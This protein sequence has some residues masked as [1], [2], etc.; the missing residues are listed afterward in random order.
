MF[1]PISLNSEDNRSLW[2]IGWVCFFWST[3]SLM[4]F[5]LLPTFLTE[6]LGVSKTQLGLIEGMAIFLAF[7]AKVLSGVVSDLYQKRKPLI[8]LG[9]VMSV[10]TKVL[11][12]WANSMAMVF[13]ARAVDR[14]SKG[15]RTAPTDALIADL[16]PPKKEGVSFG[17]RQSLYA[18]GTAFGSLLAAFI[19]IYSHNNYRLVFGLAIVPAVLALYV[20]IKWVRE[21]KS[22]LQIIYKRTPWHIKEIKNLPPAFWQLLGI[23]TFLMLARFSEAFLNIRAKEMGWAVAYLPLLFVAYDFICGLF[24]FPMGRMVDESDRYKILLLGILILVLTNILIIAW[25]SKEGI[26]V[27]I[28]M[29]GLHMGTTQGVI[30]SMIAEVTP[31]N[32]RGTAFAL[33]YLLSGLSILAGNTIAGLLSDYVGSQGAFLGGLVFSLISAMVCIRTMY[34]TRLYGY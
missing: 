27:G 13:L 19:M 5:T 16:S 17:L 34:K 29:A 18:F 15:I 9:S 6:E 21:P 31:Q 22:T 10:L 30:A 11:F 4:V 3:A 1:S 23:T 2:S 25:D 20:L 26:L 24:A 7:L 32:L 28:V 14:F 12:T 8:V 33:Y